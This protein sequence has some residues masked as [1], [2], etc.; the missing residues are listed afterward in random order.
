MGPTHTHSAQSIFSKYNIFW[1][2]SFFLIHIWFLSI[3]LNV[4]QMFDYNK[5]GAKS[6]VSCIDMWIDM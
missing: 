1:F 4:D 3:S 6:Q 5:I 2:L